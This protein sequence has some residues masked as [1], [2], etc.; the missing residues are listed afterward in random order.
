MEFASCYDQSGTVLASSIQ[1][2][3]LSNSFRP[4]KTPAQ[5]GLSPSME[6][7]SLS[8]EGAW[9]KSA[10]IRVPIRLTGG[11]SAPAEECRHGVSRDRS[12]G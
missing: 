11:V 1:A 3:V 5:A 4:R 8:G 12:W 10:D 2:R 9:A 7:F 6:A